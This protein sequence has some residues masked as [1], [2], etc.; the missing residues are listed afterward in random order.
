MR[1]SCVVRLRQKIG[2]IE[3][4]VIFNVNQSAINLCSKITSKNW[5]HWFRSYFLMKIKLFSFGKKSEMIVETIAYK[6]FKE[7]CSERKVLFQYF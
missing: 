5:L 6:E 7:G 2:Y 3:F 4:A 1:I